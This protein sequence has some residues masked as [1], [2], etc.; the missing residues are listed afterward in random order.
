[1]SID[2]EQMCIYTS[3]ASRPAPSLSNDNYP[4]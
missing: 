3:T 2:T 1:M 4:S